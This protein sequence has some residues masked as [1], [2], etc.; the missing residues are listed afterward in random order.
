VNTDRLIDLLSGNLE[1]VGR[2]RFGKTLILAMLA[3]SAAALV[4]MLV[5]VGPRADLDSAA[6][7]TWTAIKL[8]FAVSVIG[9]ATPLLLRSMRPGLEKVTHTETLFLPFLVAIAAALAMLLFVTP[10]TWTEML[11]GRTS[12]SPERCLGCV[13]FF[14]IVPFAALVW[15]LRQGAP[16]R[17]RLSGAITGVVAGGLGAAAYA[18]A[19]T[20]DS[21]H[22]RYA[23]LHCCLHW[24]SD[25]ALRIHWSATRTLAAAMVI[26]ECATS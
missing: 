15:A 12:G 7:L 17:L 6:H 24:R 10:Q 21:L 3:G 20:S 2:V 14:A 8:L 9:T 13:V 1:P 5:T 26:V 19:C 23:P 16:T 25:R 22:E 4:L 18:F 11:R